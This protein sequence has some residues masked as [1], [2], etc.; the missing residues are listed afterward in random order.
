MI[1]EESTGT[2]SRVIIRIATLD[3]LEWLLLKLQEFSAFYNTKIP[4]YASH[5]RALVGITD[6]IDNHL[7]YVAEVD[8]EQR[9]FICG[10]LRPNEINPKIR[11]LTEKFF[12]VE[13][14]FRCSSIAHRL[15]KKFIEVGKEAANIIQFGMFVGANIKES[16]MEKLGFE[17]KEKTYFMETK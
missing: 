7:I 16:S 3:D 10:Y 2:T 14:E 12:W 5:L 15:M 11:M 8:G 4:L 17:L 9:G 1:A 13:P 6:F